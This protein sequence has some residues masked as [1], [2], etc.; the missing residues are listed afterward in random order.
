[1]H[2]RQRLDPGHHRELRADV[3][4]RVGPH[5]WGRPP[6]HR[7]GRRLLVGREASQEVADLLVARVQ[8]HDVVVV[9]ELADLDELGPGPVPG[10]LVVQHHRPAVQRLELGSVL[11]AVEDVVELVGR[12]VG[13]VAVEPEGQAGR[14][15]EHVGDGRLERREL[16]GVV[17]A[18]AEHVE[19]D[20]EDAVLG[21]AVPRRRQRVVGAA[22][23]GDLA[24]TVLPRGHDRQEHVVATPGHVTPAGGPLLVHRQGVA[25]DP[26]HVQ[27]DVPHQLVPA[28]VGARLDAPQ[29][30]GPGRGLGLEVAPDHVVELVEAVHDR[31]VQ[32]GHE[33][34]GED[35]PAV[36]VQ[37]E[38][39]HR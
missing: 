3:D 26:E 10:V 13:V 33:V 24:V 35:D 36:T 31:Q 5:G 15:G 12:E 9:L 16:G 14:R 25:A 27:R 22:D 34:G 23:G 38:R 2:G 32:R 18:L 37:K 4:G 30:V 7:A 21:L 1:M 39:V 8:D 6:R 28:G 29:D 19:E 17:P 11:G 20:A